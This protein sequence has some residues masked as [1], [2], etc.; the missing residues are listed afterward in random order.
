M[1][2]CAYIFPSL[3]K[4]GERYSPKGCVSFWGREER[5]GQGE[6]LFIS[7]KHS[8]A[9]R[10]SITMIL[11]WVENCY[12]II[13]ASLST[14]SKFDS[15]QRILMH[16]QVWVLWSHGADHLKVQMGPSHLPESLP[17][18]PSATESVSHSLAQHRDADLPPRPGLPLLTILSGSGQ[19]TLLLVEPGKCHLLSLGSVSFA[20]AISPCFI[21]FPDP[22]PFAHQ[23]IVIPQ[24]L[25]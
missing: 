17:W 6:V 11:L 18:L 19:G 21:L 2:T 25:S 7:L 15:V 20:E 3:Y 4:H 10:Q 24:D 12:S 22:P 5:G 14:R 16:T 9:K 13:C 8:K 1:H 23:N